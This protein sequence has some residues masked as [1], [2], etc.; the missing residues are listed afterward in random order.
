MRVLTT[1]A[2]GTLGAFVLDALRAREIETIAWSGRSAERRSGLSLEPIDLSD[3]PTLRTALDAAD[4]DAVL[5]LAAVASADEAN[6][7]RDRAVRVNVLATETIADWCVRRDRRLVFASTDM[8]FD[9][10]S[11][12][13][14]EEDEPAPLSFYGETKRR[15]EA[16]VALVPRGLVARLALLY[17]SSKSGRST[18]F[19]QAIGDLRRGEARAFFADEYRTPLPLADA[20]EILTTLLERDRS[21]VLHVAGKERLS[22]FDLFRRAAKALGLNAD[23]VRANR[24]A[25]APT[26]EPR[27]EDLSLDTTRL[28]NLLPEARRRSIEDYLK[29]ESFPSSRGSLQ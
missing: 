1:G 9:G 5:H 25:D 22:R 28:A 15:A 4:P 16:R 10:S 11:P 13:R 3:A 19:D 8:V 20:A 2:S 7:D 6:R 17:G 14:K 12:W 27:P 18:F 26:A 23:L 29:E 21:G 24:R